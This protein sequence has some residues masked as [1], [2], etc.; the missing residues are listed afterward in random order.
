MS[1]VNFFP[2]SMRKQTSAVAVMVLASIASAAETAPNNELVLEARMTAGPATWM[3]SDGVL[4]AY[5]AGNEWRVIRRGGEEIDSGLEVQEI[6]AG[7]LVG[8]RLYVDR[9]D[10]VHVIEPGSENAIA[11]LLDLSLEE[12]TDRLLARALD[13]LLVWEQGVG[14]HVVRLPPPAGHAPPSG[15]GHCAWP[16]T[17]TPTG[18]LPSSK[19]AKALAASGRTIY[20]ALA[21]GEIAVYRLDGDG[22][23]HAAG[24]FAWIGTVRALAANGERLFVLDDE[25]LRVVDLSTWGGTAPSQ[26]F[27]PDVGGT[28]L[29]VSG[30]LIL[31]SSTQ[32]GLTAYREQ[33]ITAMTHT[34]T[35]TNFEFTPSEITIDVGDTV[36]WNNNEG[37]HNV[38]SCN[39]GETGCTTN[40]A[41][42]FSSGAAA[43]APW[44]YSHTFTQPG[45]NPYTCT[46]HA[47]FGMLGRVTV[48]AATTAPPAVPDGQP[49]TVPL[50][51][52][53]TNLN[54]S[55]L[56]V[57]FDDASCQ[58]M[59][60]TQIVGG[61]RA[62]LPAAPGGG[63]GISVSRCACGAT[64]PCVWSNSPLPSPG[65]MIWFVMVAR[66]A[67]ATEGS[68]G[69]DSAGNERQG[70]GTA[71]SS[72]QCGSTAK[73]VSNRCGI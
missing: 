26:V 71:G 3:T 14:L 17:A 33:S 22:A 37:F 52:R 39:V 23:P 27:Y 8:R 13:H 53:K 59:S 7:A 66:D 54:G 61:S 58:G 34:V 24:S 20:A 11:A 56:E 5:G 15:N 30:R 49:G 47:G 57:S 65:Q 4:I 73:D 12:G 43:S 41:E 69:T 62:E 55:T 35:L 48:N 1:S 31:I 70:P 29:A 18:F 25:G 64:S 19:P 36:Q 2:P 50:T 16:T 46:V 44:S 72:G 63:Y 67:A 32:G 45:S 68:W 42:S 6:R 51:V 28:A 9:P 10:G 60:G 40:A 21:G 38:N